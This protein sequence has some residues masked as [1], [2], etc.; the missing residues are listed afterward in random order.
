MQTF[1]RI[2]FVIA[3]L[4]VPGLLVGASIEMQDQAGKPQNSL[5]SRSATA[6]SSV[7]KADKPARH[8]LSTGGCV[9]LAKANLRRRTGIAR[10]QGSCFG[11]YI[12][13]R[14]S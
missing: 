12:T 5:F 8:N 3:V 1:F 9:V 14:A 6:S 11:C 10:F 4:I 13:L 2:R 7:A